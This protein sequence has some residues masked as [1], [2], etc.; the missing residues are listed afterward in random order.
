MLDVVS[1]PLASLLLLPSPFLSFLLTLPYRDTLAEKVP[2]LHC[3]A[4]TPRK[5]FISVSNSE[6]SFRDSMLSRQ[7][8][9]SKTKFHRVSS[10]ST[11]DTVS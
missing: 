3:L 7:S 9:T 2:C 6:S 1:L 8:S 5:D 11:G 10:M 4:Q